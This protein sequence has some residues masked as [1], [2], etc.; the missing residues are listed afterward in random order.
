MQYE[1]QVGVDNLFATSTQHVVSDVLLIAQA[2]V[3]KRGTLLTEAGAMVKASEEVYAVLAEDVDTTEAAKEAAV[4]LTGE[5]NE[6][7]LTVDAG[8]AVADFKKSAR[9]V[10]IFIKPCM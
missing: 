1:S 9:K 5:F 3:V 7:A 6:K 2:G 10:C 8:S 4:Y